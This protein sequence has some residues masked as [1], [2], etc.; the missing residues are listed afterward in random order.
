MIER[1]LAICQTKEDQQTWV[2][3]I[4]QQI[5]NVRVSSPLP[6]SPA[7]PTPPPHSPPVSEY[8]SP[9]SR[10]AAHFARLVKKGV[11]TRK[12][13]KKLLYSEFLGVKTDSVSRRGSHRTECV[14][15]PQKAVQTW[16][17]ESDSSDGES[18]SESEL[19][20]KK[21]LSKLNVLCS[22]VGSDASSC[23][24]Y[25]KGTYRSTLTISRPAAGICSDLTRM[26]SNT[27]MQPAFNTLDYC[28][29]NYNQHQSLPVPSNTSHH[30]QPAHS[31]C[32]TLPPNPVSVAEI[33][34]D[35]ISP[36]SD[37]QVRPI[38]RSFS[39]HYIRNDECQ[40]S[41]SH[42]SSDSGLA[43][44]A[45]PDLTTPGPDLSLPPESEGSGNYEAQCVC[46]SPFGSTPRTSPQPTSPSSTVTP[47]YRSGMYAHWCF[48]MRI[49]AIN[50]K[51]PT[52]KHT[53]L[54]KIN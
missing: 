50:V 34:T 51:A 21:S 37:E 19:E 46:T 43:D 44:I 53:A 28:N 18:D 14:I 27:A 5:R 38:H 24:G 36:S 26:D 17:S 4:R 23:L 54:V 15:Y 47:T 10:L 8:S 52:G 29:F 25:V 40:Y 32:L 13:L 2:D 30:I 20:G 39:Y 33:I 41:G 9:Y 49:P 48:K 6:T 35:P 45:S 42:R 12:V 16:V 7:R 11:I 22:S 31:S 3:L 1:I